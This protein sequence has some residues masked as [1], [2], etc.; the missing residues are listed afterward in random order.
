MTNQDKYHF[1]LRKF[2]SLIGLLVVG[3]F[4]FFHGMINSTISNGFGAEVFNKIA[5]SLQYVPYIIMVELALGFFILF[6]AIYGLVII[7]KA[8]NNP[9]QYGFWRNLRFLFQRYSGLVILGFILF[10]VITMKYGVYAHDVEPGE[11]GMFSII[12]PWLSS[13][14]GIV[15]YS[16]G[17]IA[18]TFHLANGIWGFLITWGITTGK[19]AQKISAWACGF[20]FIA[21]TSVFIA[22]M[23]VMYIKAQDPGNLALPSPLL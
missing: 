7:Y 8:H 1:V 14:Y 5:I 23:L 15:I 19:K 13:W 11:N 2:H 12:A 20:I 17:I 18:A 22:V 9:I 10:H 3:I 21:I 16:L 6:H 4:L